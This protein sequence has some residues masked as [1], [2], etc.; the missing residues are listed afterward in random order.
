MVCATPSLE[1][2]GCVAVHEPVLS[3]ERHQF[4]SAVAPRAVSF[5]E[6]EHPP[7]PQL[8]PALAVVA[9][10]ITPT[11][12]IAVTAA[13]ALP[14]PLGSTFLENT[15]DSSPVGSCEGMNSSQEASA[16]HGRCQR[17]RAAVKLPS[18]GG[19]GGELSPKG[20]A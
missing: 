3:P 15:E 18:G 19:G 16:I 2:V 4:L 14:S 11:T 9:E 17:V 10:P 7:I 5:T 13:A 20:A 12:V 6:D 1:Q 8:A